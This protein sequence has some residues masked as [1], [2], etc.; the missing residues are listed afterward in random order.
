MKDNFKIIVKMEKVLLQNPIKD[1]RIVNDH[2]FALR[3][4][5][6][7]NKIEVYDL[8]DNLIQAFDKVKDCSEFVKRKTATILEGLKRPNYICAK[9]YKLKKVFYED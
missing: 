4:L 2:T 1:N 8:Q 3:L 6:F 7:L 9:K 5:N